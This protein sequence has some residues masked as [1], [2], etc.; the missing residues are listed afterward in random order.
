MPR[1]ISAGNS[2]THRALIGTARHAGSALLRM[3]SDE[4]LIDL[5]RAGN[6]RA[7]EAIVERYRGPLERH[8]ERILPRSRAEDAVQQAFLQAYRSITAHE[9]NLDLRPWLYRVA[10]NC[11][12]DALRQSG[13]NHEELD[14]R[15]DGVERPHQALKR[16]DRIR[17]VV[18]AIQELP[19]RQREVLLAREFEGRSYGEIAV[20]LGVSDGAVRQLLNRARNTL[21]VGISS[22]SPV[23]LVLR[24]TGV[25]L[26]RGG[27]IAR[28]L[29]GAAAGGGGGL[30][31]IGIGMLTVG[32]LLTGAGHGS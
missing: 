5:T 15:L 4:R 1:R 31:K 14:K 2:V 12:L 17:G 3:Q 18:A 16:A 23:G 24:L 22:L 25:E 10:H 26:P 20:A 21:R 6:R 13:W 28:P 32:A 7:F 8:C 29:A 9:A 30:A 27:P 19:P 11:A